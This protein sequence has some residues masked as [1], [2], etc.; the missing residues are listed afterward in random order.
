MTTDDV[1]NTRQK[2]KQREPYWKPG[3]KLGGQGETGD[4]APHVTYFYCYKKI[5][6]GEQTG[7][8]LRQKMHILNHVWLRYYVADNQD[9]VATVK[10]S[11]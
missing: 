7:F 5:M 9:M 10:R 3:V 8:W 1:Q 6:K 11:K 2:I 4:V